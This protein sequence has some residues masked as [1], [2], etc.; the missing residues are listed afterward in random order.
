MANS[1]TIDAELNVS[2]GAQ[3]AI[4]RAMAALTPYEGEPRVAALVTKLR[5]IESPS[6]FDADRVA[7]I[8]KALL[9]CQSLA[10]SED[11][12]DLVK[13]KAESARV[14]LEKSYLERMSPAG[15]DVWKRAMQAQGRAV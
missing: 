7:E 15:S 4:R 8:S 6:D 13:A 14:E 3:A 1:N 9:D 5:A 11:V 12:S 2:T 10:K